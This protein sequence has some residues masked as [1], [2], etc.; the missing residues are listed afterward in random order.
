MQEIGSLARSGGF[1][2]YSLRASRR[3]CFQQCPR[4]CCRHEWEEECSQLLSRREEEAGFSPWDQVVWPERSSQHQRA[5]LGLALPGRALHLTALLH[6]HRVPTLLFKC[7]RNLILT[8]A[9]LAEVLNRKAS[10]FGVVRSYQ[11]TKAETW[12]PCSPTLV[13][14]M[15]RSFWGVRKSTLVAA[16]RRAHKA[17]KHFC[18]RTS[19]DFEPSVWKMEWNEYK[20]GNEQ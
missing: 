6:L 10:A 4:S 8:Q 9:V 11:L 3:A 7:K 17:F 14:F 12:E 5:A 1:Q 18:W 2:S 16:L 19:W 13:L 20:W 15:M